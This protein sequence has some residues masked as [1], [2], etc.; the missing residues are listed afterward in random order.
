VECELAQRIRMRV[1][2]MPALLDADGQIGNAIEK[3]LARQHL[4]A[5]MNTG[6]FLFL[7]QQK[8]Q[9]HSATFINEMTISHSG[10]S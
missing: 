10:C 6:G 1:A 5:D 2:S 9:D 3:V 8:I 7:F 4:S